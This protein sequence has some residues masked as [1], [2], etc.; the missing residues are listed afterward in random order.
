MNNNVFPSEMINEILTLMRSPKANWSPVTIHEHELSYGIILENLESNGTNTYDKG[1]VTT[2]CNDLCQ[3]DSIS[4]T[5]SKHIPIALNK[6]DYYHQFNALQPRYYSPSRLEC[7]NKDHK[8][9]VEGYLQY[10][11]DALSMSKSTLKGKRFSAIYFM[12]YL[13]VV[14]I[15]ICET[16]A[17]T[18]IDYLVLINTEKA[19]AETTKNMNLYQDRLF[20]NYLIQY[21]EMPSETV[22][23]LQ[24][25]FG[26]H[27]VHLPSYYEP[28]EIRSLLNSIDIS[29]NAGKRDY[30]ICLLVSQL[31]LRASD[32]SNLAFPHIHW[33]IETIELFQKKTKA[34]LVLPLLANIKFAILDYWKNARPES[35]SEHVLLTQSRPHRRLSSDYLSI[36]VTERL[37]NAGISIQGRKHG[38]HAMRHSLARN[39]LSNN[40][41]LSTI[42]GILGHKNSNTTRKYLGIDTKGLRKIALEVCYGQK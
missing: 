12:N 31:G 3:K 14:G 6:L 13:A 35:D 24:V 27:E 10:C 17:Q 36:I 42:T 25:I 37:L 20:L 16:D 2:I 18:I 22:T 15:S 21:H 28:E 38:C 23:P 8:S 39:L 34:L 11:R 40:E 19:W 26:C 33:D 7:L 4:E 5:R 9:V 32:V 41:A 1:V 29:S 30:L